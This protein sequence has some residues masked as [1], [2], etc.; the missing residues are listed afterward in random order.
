MLWEGTPFGEETKTY[1]TFMSQNSLLFPQDRKLTMTALIMSS[2]L[3]AYKATRG[4]WMG[5]GHYRRNRLAKT[6]PSM[7]P[8]ATCTNLRGSSRLDL[9]P[10]LLYP[11]SPTAP[12]LHSLPASFL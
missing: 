11:L 12:S 10:S 7:G 5:A 4:V 8:M 9:I 6:G 1:F 2:G 3:G